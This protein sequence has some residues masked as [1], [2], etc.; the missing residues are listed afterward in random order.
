MDIQSLQMM[1]QNQVIPTQTSNFD[2]LPPQSSLMETT[3]RQLL[4]DRINQATMLNR[5]EVLQSTTFF[6]PLPSQPVSTISKSSS[7][8]TT[9]FN[10]IIAETADKY[11]ISQQLIHSVIKAESN[12]RSNA[13]S[14]AG[15]E[16]LMQLMPGTARGLG[17]KN[18]YDPKQNVE[19]GT[20]Y[21]SQMLN[22]YN[23]NLELALAAYNAGP[24]NVDKYNGIPPF[25]E[26]QQ[27]VKKVMNDYLA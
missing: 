27:Y 24:G 10:D 1:I 25:K 3:F 11:G 8:P 23:G 20:K 19:G 13:R 26:T 9:Q 12:Y 16:G 17:V 15:A 21:L 18:S 7:L 6:Q 14:S 5:P 4:Q 2:R 22:K